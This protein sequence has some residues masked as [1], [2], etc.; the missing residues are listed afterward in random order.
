MAGF[1]SEVKKAEIVAGRRSKRR[2]SRFANDSPLSEKSCRVP[3]SPPPQS[4]RQLQ[5]LDTNSFVKARQEIK[6][7]K[8]AERQNKETRF[9]PKPPGKT[10]MVV[11]L[12]ESIDGSPQ[13]KGRS[14]VNQ[15]I[16]KANGYVA[17]LLKKFVSAQ[18]TPLET[19]FTP[20]H[21]LVRKDTWT[22]PTKPVLKKPYKP[23][24]WQRY[25]TKIVMEH[26]QQ[27][28]H[29]KQSK[30]RHK[31]KIPDT[32]MYTTFLSMNQ[33]H[34]KRAAY[35]T[36]LFFY[37]GSVDAGKTLQEKKNKTFSKL[38]AAMEKKWSG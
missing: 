10:S 33:P 2:I 9:V 35:K 8:R 19:S 32:E 18:V 15:D 4:L 37:V 6:K 13:P 28:L 1:Q 29:S 34:E 14:S 22:L 36:G 5:R 20:V 11:E 17:S 27:V 30:S 7:T 24:N 3:E 38:S 23:F 21:P 16:T 31:A 12:A 25:G 26:N